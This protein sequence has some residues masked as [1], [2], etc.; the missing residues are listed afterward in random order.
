MILAGPPNC[1]KSTYI[2]N[3]VVHADP[4]FQQVVTISPDPD[5]TKEYEDIEHVALGSCPPPQEFPGDKKLLVIIDD[6]DETT[7]TFGYVSTHKNASIMWGIQDAMKCPTS[8]RR[9]A[10]VFVLAKSP[11]IA[12]TAALATRSGLNPSQLSSLFDCCVYPHDSITID[13]TPNSPAPIR[14]NCFTIL[15]QV[16]KVQHERPRDIQM[17]T[18]SASVWD[19][20]T[21]TAGT[22]RASE[23]KEKRKANR[24]AKEASKA[25]RVSGAGSNSTNNKRAKTAYF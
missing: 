11:D 8:A 13:T 20:S 18:T 15:E 16:G 6:M 22:G 14:F 23:Q 10:N 12:A 25:H 3:V 24:K 17:E 7:M 5:F 2:K 9:A 19:P 1:G 4:P 21:A